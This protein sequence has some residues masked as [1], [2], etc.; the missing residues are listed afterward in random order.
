MDQDSLNSSDNK[1][2]S[3][4]HFSPSGQMTPS[5]PSTEEA[6]NLPARVRQEKAGQGHF[7]EERDFR[8]YYRLR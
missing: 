7:P 3:P 4:T 2:F 8:E 6:R 1:T 5:H